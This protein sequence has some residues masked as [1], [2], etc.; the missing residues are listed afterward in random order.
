MSAVWTYWDA[1]GYE[2]SA[3]GWGWGVY[4]YGDGDGD[5]DGEVH[6][7]PHYD[8]KNHSLHADCPCVP[9]FRDGALVHN[10]WD[11][12]EDYETYGRQVN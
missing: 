4:P 9:I 7:V 1:E 3:G 8:D 11:K 2:N 12:R 5:G 10:A 6:V